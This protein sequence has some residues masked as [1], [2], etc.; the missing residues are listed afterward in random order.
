MALESDFLASDLIGTV[1]DGVVLFDR[2][3]FVELSDTGDVV[4]GIE[5]YVDSFFI[6]LK[7]SEPIENWVGLLEKGELAEFNVEEATDFNLRCEFGDLAE[8]PL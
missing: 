3:F 7:I 6:L 4:R 5:T 1:I 8:S 2:T